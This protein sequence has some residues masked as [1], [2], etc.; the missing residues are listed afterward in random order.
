MKC[1]FFLCHNSNYLRSFTVSKGPWTSSQV[2][3]N[4]WAVICQNA[5]SENVDGKRNF[6]SHEQWLFD[7]AK[8][9]YQHIRKSQCYV[10]NLKNLKVCKNG[11]INSWTVRVIKIQITSKFYNFERAFQI[12]CKSSLKSLY[13]QNEIH[14]IQ[15]SHF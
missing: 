11:K 6:S 13:V 2:P 15:C 4:S 3:W 10:T 5:Q 14:K 12:I 9:T 7:Y 8:K 1:L